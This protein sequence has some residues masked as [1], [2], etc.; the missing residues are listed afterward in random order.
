MVFSGFSGELGG[1]AI[2]GCL[3]RT[4]LIGLVKQLQELLLLL[5]VTQLKRALYPLALLKL[6]RGLHSRNLGAPVSK[7]M[8][9]N[10]LASFG[11]LCVLTD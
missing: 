4:F 11:P 6:F 8:V 2:P 3:T 7:V 1:A 9:T 5:A 10:V